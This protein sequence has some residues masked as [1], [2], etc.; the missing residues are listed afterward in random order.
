MGKK[1]VLH[2][3]TFKLKALDQLHFDNKAMVPPS[4]DERG[5]AAK[6]HKEKWSVISC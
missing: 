4:G 1:R 6:T 5:C 2:G 3:E